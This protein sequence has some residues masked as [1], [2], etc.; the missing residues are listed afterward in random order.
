MYSSTLLARLQCAGLHHHQGHLSYY[1]IGVLCLYL[2]S[3]AYCYLFICFSVD[4]N[5][6]T[7]MLHIIYILFLFFLCLLVLHATPDSIE[8]V[9]WGTWLRCKRFGSIVE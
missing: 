2:L 3:V 9:N 5:I 1:L 6:Q 7:N 8:L 4:E